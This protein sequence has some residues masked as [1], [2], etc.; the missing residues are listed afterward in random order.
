[1]QQ[2][3]ISQSSEAAVVASGNS[4][5]AEVPAVKAKK[6][7]PKK[8]HKKL[9]I[10]SI[11][12]LII[13][14]WF[15]YSTY[16]KSTFIPTVIAQTASKQDLKSFLST[17]TT[18]FSPDS[19]A[20]F[21][22]PNS[23]AQTVNFK[24]GDK[25]KAGDVIATYD[26]TDLENQIAL[27]QIAYSDAK[28][29]QQNAVISKENAELSKENA[30]LS[31]EDVLKSDEDREKEIDDLTRDIQTYNNILRKI[32]AGGGPP[33]EITDATAQRYILVESKLTRAIQE[34]DQLQ[35]TVTKD[36]TIAQSKNAIASA[37]NTVKNANNAITSAGNA[38]KSAS[39]NIASL[40]KYV[41]TSGIVAEFDGIITE[42]N[43]I[44]GG[45]SPASTACVIQ[46]TEELKG[47]FNIG[48]YDL[49]TVQPGQ[50][51]VLTLGDLT[52]NGV[53]SK[54]GSAAIK[55]PN[56]SGTGTSAAQVPAEISILN[57]DDKLVIGLDFDVDIETASKTGVVAL[58]V[59][60]VLTD[61]EGEFCYKLVPAEK[62]NT[63]THEKVYVKTGVAS[64][65]FIEILSGIAEG[66]KVIAT[67]PTTI[68]M[69]PLVQVT[70]EPAAAEASTSE[71]SA[72]AA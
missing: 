20:Y 23:K 50:T 8:K 18:I 34:R 70:P 66:D 31:N 40:Q 72:S 6:P 38:M 13:A 25:V 5:I 43:L 17:S 51:A 3:T 65:A 22:P 60:A 28:L 14:G 12:I 55:T 1:M 39:I 71:T 49:G 7:K 2:E 56:A 15:G 19:T 67:P 35:S 37:D 48:K 69:L 26:L 21:A 63:Y 11:I 59:E 45:T 33:T 44:E 64:D 36:G 16:K 9:I 57:A 54:I 58:P 42:M 10:W 52:Y 27:A 47:S 41:E 29:A 62:E 24:V 30:E 53:V 32:E 61:R 4:A 46:T 68:D